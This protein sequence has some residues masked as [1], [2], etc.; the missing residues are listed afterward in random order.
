[1]DEKEPTEEVVPPTNLA[2]DVD[3]SDSGDGEVTVIASATGAKYFVFDFNEYLEVVD[4]RV[5]G[6]TAT[7]TYT[8][9]NPGDYKITVKAHASSTKSISEKRISPSKWIKR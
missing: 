9:S 1:M 4:T 7:A 5:D 2:L 8:Y 3:V 6:S